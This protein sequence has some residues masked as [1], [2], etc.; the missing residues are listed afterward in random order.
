MSVITNENITSTNVPYQKI[1]DIEIEQ[2]TEEH[3]K[4]ILGLEVQ[5]EDGI[6]F[7]DSA[8]P[9]LHAEIT[10]SAEGFAFSAVCVPLLDNTNNSLRMKSFT[11]SMS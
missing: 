11:G 1:M 4:A 2:K 7:A 6:S 5:E 3:A 8:G 9:D 10:T